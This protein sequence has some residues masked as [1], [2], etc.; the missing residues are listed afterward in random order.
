MNTCYIQCWQLKSDPPGFQL[1]ALY[2]Q[3]TTGIPVYKLIFFNLTVIFMI[4]TYFWY[5]GKFR[6]NVKLGD[7][8]PVLKLPKFKLHRN[9]GV[10]Q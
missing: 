3:C 8:G 4:F 6:C 10:I 5:F 9:K 7:P 2:V 1:P